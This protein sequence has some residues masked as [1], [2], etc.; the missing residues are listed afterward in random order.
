[1]ITET[2]EVARALDDAAKRWPAD[3][4]SRA[5]L[6]VHLV[7]EGHRALGGRAERAV[8]D[9]R[10]A[11]ARTSGVLTGIYGDGYLRRL[12]EDWPT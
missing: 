5:K 12:R 11:I 8:R 1:V 7:E 9:R 6:L 4:N 10:E 3:S 2:D